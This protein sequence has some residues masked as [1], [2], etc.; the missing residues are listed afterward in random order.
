MSRSQPT[1]VD[2]RVFLRRAGAAAAAPWIIPASAR[3]AGG[4]PAPS[5][6]ITLGFIGVG[7]MGQGHL[8]AFL[9]YPETQVL[10]ICDVDRW[11]RETAQ[12]T[13]DT[14]YAAGRPSG[15]WRGC[16]TPWYLREALQFPLPDGLKPILRRL[17][18]LTQ[19]R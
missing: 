8:G 16:A 5:N 14:A 17:D 7:M 3:G 15:S 12:S 9:Q 1:A 13:V 6:R 2:R 18:Q 4:V 10:A 19:T 11:R